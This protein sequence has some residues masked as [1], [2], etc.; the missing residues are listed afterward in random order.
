MPMDYLLYPA[1]W[2]VRARALKLACDYRCQRCGLRQGDWTV[3]RLGVPVQIGVAH[4]DH[5][6]WNPEARL[7]VLCR[8]CHLRYDAR[9]RRRK[10]WCM[11]IAR[12]QQLLWKEVMTAQ[13]NRSPWPGLGAPARANEAP[14]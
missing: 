3:N 11:Q 7:Q 1:D 12:G 8:A 10:Q 5:D 4:L 14:V 9:Q 2:D 6:P 13:D